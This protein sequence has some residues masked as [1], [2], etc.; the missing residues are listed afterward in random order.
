VPENE[1]SATPRRGVRRVPQ[2]SFLYQRIIPIALI[3]LGIL[4]FVIVVVALGFLF[5]LVRL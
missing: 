3:G 5:G 2:Q 4:L 1:K